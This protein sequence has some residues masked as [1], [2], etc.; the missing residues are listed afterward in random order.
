MKSEPRPELS[1]YGARAER[2][3]RGFSSTEIEGD[4]LGILEVTDTPAYFAN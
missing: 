3:G 2:L 1:R 4:F